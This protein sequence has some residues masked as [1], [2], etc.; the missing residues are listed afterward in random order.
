M[1]ARTALTT[2]ALADS[3]RRYPR[4]PA[5]RARN[6]CAAVWS[7]ERMMTLAEREALFIMRVASIPFRTG[8]AMSMRTTS[9]IGAAPGGVLDKIQGVVYLFFRKPSGPE[10]GACGGGIRE[11][12][13]KI[14]IRREKWHG[15]IRGN[16]HEG[17]TAH[18]NRP[19]RQ[20]R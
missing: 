9:G 5:C 4:A 11:T 7:I 3:L 17:K 18:R 14:L 8:M 15:T 16:N 1:T 12:K 20:G 2:S 13:D 10:N 19:R 6:T